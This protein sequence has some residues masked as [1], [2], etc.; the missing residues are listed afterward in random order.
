MTISIVIPVFNEESELP[1]CLDSIAK[2]TVAPDEVVVVDNN[3]TDASMEIARRYGFVTITHEPRQGRGHA[4]TAGCNAA[5]SEIIG[6]IDADSELDVD[7][8]KR[9]KELFE[10]DA[11]LQGVTGLGRATIIPRSSLLKT[12]IFA[13]GY[14]WFVHALFHTITMW[15]A[16]MA[17]RKSAWEDVADKVIDDD[18]LVHEDQDLS[19]WMAAQGGKII[20]DNHLLIS[21]YGQRY[22]NTVKIFEYRRLINSTK[23]LHTNNGNLRSPNLRRL[24]PSST[25]LGFL[26]SLGLGFVIFLFSLLFLP[27]DVIRSR[28]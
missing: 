3:C 11:G 8:V 19:L 2:Q 27:L 28:R 5:K 15:G 10:L 12:T 1:K 18:S 7:W 14:Y 13:R 16:N 6:R 22:V 20:Q 23:E 25:A 24:K 26:F 4:R 9:V 21:T 17:I